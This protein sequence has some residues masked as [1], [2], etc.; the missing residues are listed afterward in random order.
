MGN[1]TAAVA[2]DFRQEFADFEG[3]TYLNTSL[4][5]PLPLVAARAAQEA[6]EWKK[7]PYRIADSAYFDLPDGIRAKVASTIGANAEEIAVT[8]GASSGMACVAAG[9]DWKAGDEV[10]V[11]R[12][13]FP[14]HF[15]TWMRYAEAGKLRI[16]T[17]EPRGRFIEAEDYVA[18]IG[19]QT[20]VV[21]ASL[22]RFDNG[23]MLDAHRVSRACEKVGAA[24][25]LDLSQCAGAMT[26][27]IRG[28]GATMAV[29][30][31]YKW[32]LGPYGTGFFWI[33][34]EWIERLPLGAVY[35]MA[36]EGAHDFH[37]L[38]SDV[39][40][41]APGARRWD[42]AEPANFANLAAFDA[43]LELLQRIGVGAI[44]SH[45]G[46]L[47]NEIIERLPRDICTLASPEHCERRGPFVCISAI[48]PNDS[49]ALHDKL[50]AANVSVSLRGTALR[51]SPY[52]HNTSDDISRLI[53]TLR[54]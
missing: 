34:S 52:L 44:E 17:V 41:P 24:L 18:Q 46:S 3:V 5:G 45:V 37:A 22:V 21:T 30:S 13:E 11:G 33:A 47:V 42:S 27:D 32:M 12:G 15:S 16:R 43:S 36:L 8:T 29:S 2:R 49:R 39:L 9:I 25:L 26:I 31:G 14:S 19:S 10:L 28:L 48:N 4:Q 1:E 54:S 35:F 6:L 23:A 40:R 20:R 38:P 50:K 53:E 51:V 7:H